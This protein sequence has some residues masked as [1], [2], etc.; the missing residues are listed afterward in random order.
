MEH[1]VTLPVSENPRRFGRSTGAVIAGFLTVLL[2]H[3]GSDAIL[4]AAGVFPKDAMLSSEQFGLALAYRTLFTVLGGYVT[5]RLAPHKPLKHAL[6][7]GAVGAVP[8]MAGLI[9][10][11]VVTPKLGPVWYPLALLLATVPAC[12]LGGRIFEGRR[13]AAS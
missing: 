7:L 5:A 10:T 13:G 1:L 6:L 4:H 2:T 8:C 3:T 9:A 11:I 12:W